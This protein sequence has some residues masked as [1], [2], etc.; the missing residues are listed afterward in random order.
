MIQY[1]SVLITFKIT[2]YN[3][4]VLTETFV[5]GENGDAYESQKPK[6]AAHIL[7]S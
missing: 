4:F 1:V 5:P 6:Q 7:E 3:S 2:L